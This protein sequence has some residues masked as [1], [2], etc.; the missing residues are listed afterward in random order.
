[1]DQTAPDS[2]PD[3]AAAPR[4]SDRLKLLT[5]ANLAVLGA[6]VVAGSFAFLSKPRSEQ[7]RIAVVGVDADEANGAMVVRDVVPGDGGKRW[8]DISYT[9]TLRNKANVDMI[10]PWSLDE[11]FVGEVPPTATGAAFINAPPVP[12]G[13][14]P[15]GAV[16]WKLIGSQVSY[17]WTE[18][19]LDAGSSSIDENDITNFLDEAHIP[20][21][22]ANSGLIGLYGPGRSSA[23]TAHFH[24]QA[25]PE[26][27]ASV[28]VS[29]GTTT[30]EPMFGDPPDYLW[31]TRRSKFETVRLGDAS[32]AKCS[33]GIIIE[34]AM[35]R[36][37]CTPAASP[38][39]A[40]R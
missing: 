3:I 16:K 13:D 2:V 33:L 9:A 35:P 38:V 31:D 34:N 24:F 26:Q 23:H 37:G 20:T 30:H 8:Y 28:M 5:I 14:A 6:V 7:T 40:R 4:R 39:A 36:D 21:E 15:Q 11:L 22:N 17:M 1:M 10:V 25:L 27:Y 19:G 32:A 18:E 29:Y 12:N